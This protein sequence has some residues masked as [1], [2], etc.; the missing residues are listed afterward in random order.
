MRVGQEKM[1]AE[2]VADLK[3]ATRLRP[4][5][6]EPWLSLA[7]ADQLDGRLEDASKDLDTAIAV[8]ERQLRAEDLKP[9]KLAELHY[10][11]AQLHLQRSVR[12]AAEG[13]GAEVKR[14]REA[15]E[16]HLAKAER[17]AE[18]D[19]SW[20]ARTA[21]DRG[22]VLH[23]LE[24]YDEALAAY[25]EALEADPTRVD[26]LLWQGQVLLAEAAELEKGDQ[27]PLA[28]NKYGDAA[29]AF[30][31]YLEKASV[32]SPAVYQQRGLAHAKLGH[33]D[34][35]IRDYTRALEAKLKDEEK[36][37]LYRCRGQEHLNLQEF[38]LALG[39]FE[40]ALQLDR[41]NAD[42]YLGRAHVQIRLG[43]VRKAAADAEKVVE[44]QPKEP[45]LWLGAARIYA[46]AAAH[47]Q[48]Q[49]GQLMLWSNYR[50]RAEQ[51]LR[52]ALGLVPA[53]DLPAFWRE[54]VMKDK[55]LYPIASRL[56]DLVARFGGVH[57]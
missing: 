22:R 6:H 47:L 10:G 18:N 27:S 44:D 57:P 25:D 9:Q 49:P 2:G 40:D 41:K 20:R 28:R 3:T 11:Q 45:R 46:Q 21:A 12:Q 24:R 32:P 53:Q 16:G 31:A 33:H 1:R 52:K 54:K 36:A 19:R 43:D 55:V 38:K 5:K 13:H 39:D 50:K 48:A 56:D 34:R 23:L 4:D 51:L 7:M 30:D 26:I 35:A 15:A 29:T 42:A 8:A 14:L 17:L 37:L